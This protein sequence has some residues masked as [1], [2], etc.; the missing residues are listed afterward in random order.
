MTALTTLGLG[1]LIPLG[2]ALPPPEV[3]WRLALVGVGMGLHGGPTQALVLGAAP[4][5]RAATAAS[6]LQ[7]SRPLGFALGPVPAAAVWGLAGQAHGVR[8]GIAFAA[9]AAGPAVPLLTLRRQPS[10]TAG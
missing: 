6:T 8:A 5:G 7:L 9:T 10:T 2:E 1:P 4:P 3:A